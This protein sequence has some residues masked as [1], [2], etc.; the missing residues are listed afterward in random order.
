MWNNYFYNIQKKYSMRVSSREPLIIRLDGKNITK[1]KKVNLLDFCSQKGF[2]YSMEKTVEYF[3]M[4]YKCYAIYGS[5][6]VSFIF[7]DPMELMSDLDSES[8]NHSN[9]IVS[10]FSQYFFHYF[11]NFDINKLVFF[12]AKCFS[13]PTG[14]IISYIKYRSRIIENVMITYFLKENNLNEKDLKLD[15]KIDKCKS[16]DNYYII[17]KIKK[18]ILYFNGKQIILDEFFKG[19]TIYVQNVEERFSDFFDFN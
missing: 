11:N 19:N 3:T 16:I 9:E 8:D 2:M 5:D 17:E 10:L 13:I 15:E 7:M 18:G 4:K 1:N 6:E 12:H 14:K